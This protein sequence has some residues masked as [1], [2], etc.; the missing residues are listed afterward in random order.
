MTPDRSPSFEAGRRVG[1]ALGLLW[2]ALMT[3]LLWAAAVLAIL[4]ALT[5]L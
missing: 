3:G 5:S 1:A 4:H 2:C